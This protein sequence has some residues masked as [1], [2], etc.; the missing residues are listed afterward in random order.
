MS[1]V[2]MEVVTDL[3]AVMVQ[4]YDE[5]PVVV[6]DEDMMAGCYDVIAAVSMM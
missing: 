3:R 5:R 1:H 4:I 6:W 2:E